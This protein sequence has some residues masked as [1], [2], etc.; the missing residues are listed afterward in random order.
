MKNVIQNKT[1]PHFLD[2][3]NLVE[4]TNDRN[5]FKCESKND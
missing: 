5:Y 3:F 4:S 1:L 2:I